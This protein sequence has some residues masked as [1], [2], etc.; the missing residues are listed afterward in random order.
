[1]ETRMTATRISAAA[2]LALVLALGP[3][4]G[5]GDKTE[6]VLP[7]GPTVS[8]INPTTGPAAGGTPATLTGTNFTAFTQV[9]VGGAPA[10][11]VTFVN[12]TTLT[13]TTP[14]GAAGPKNVQAANDFGVGT[15]VGG[16]TYLPTLLFAADGKSGFAGFLHAVDPVTGV[17][18]AIGQVGFAITGLTM[19]TDGFLYGTESTTGSMARL[20]RI[21]P[22][23]GA[24][25][26]VGPLEDAAMVPHSSIADLTVSNGV[27]FGWSENGDQPVTIDHLTG[28]VTVVGGGTG[29]SGSGIAADAVGTIFSAPGGVNGTLNTVDPLTGVVTVGP[30]LS[31]A[32]ANVTEINALAF[33]SGT[34]YALGN[35]SGVTSPVELYT[36]DPATGV[37]TLVIAYPPGPLDGRAFDSLAGLAP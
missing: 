10:D 27:L 13:F 32:S 29:S 35:Q 15:L 7:P 18:T 24:G 22:V 31:G 6:F 17:T 16:F 33:L 12:A 8:A 21:N 30:A 14:V 26:V 3:G 11:N 23:T 36:I 37:M 34:L 2:A 4:C 9:I 1:M 5:G 28:L 20:I 19:F 25:T